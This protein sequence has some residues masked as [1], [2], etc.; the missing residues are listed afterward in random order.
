MFCT[1]CGNQIDSTMASC[2]KCG[3]PVGGR[4]PAQVAQGEIKNHMVGAILQTVVCI[5]AGI[6]PL[7]YACKVNS[8]LAQGDVAGAQEASKKAK[9]WLN[10]TT[11]IFGAII[12]LAIVANAVESTKT[13]MAQERLQAELQ[14]GE[15]TDGSVVFRSPE[16]WSFATATNDKGVVICNLTKEDGDAISL[17]S[18]LDSNDT[19]DNFEQCVETV[20]NN[21]LEKLPHRTLAD[22]EFY[23]NNHKAFYRI[24]EYENENGQTFYRH[25]AV[26]FDSGTGRAVLLGR[27]SRDQ[28]ESIIKRLL[29][30]IRFYK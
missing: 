14:E 12:V 18:A 20:Q 28:D 5:H 22:W 11:I 4:Q 21:D 19:K 9:I 3:T 8:T 2:T 30:S 25:I 23:V 7:I 17:Y 13:Q 1:N 26:V 27:Y 15:F 6:D 24:M 16:G 10:L 29:Q